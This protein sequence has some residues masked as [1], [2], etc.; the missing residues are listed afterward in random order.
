MDNSPIAVSEK[1]EPFPGMETG[2]KMF[3][4]NKADGQP[5]LPVSLITS[6]S[7]G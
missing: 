1:T 7:R 2:Y 3:D 4:A 6:I 5:T